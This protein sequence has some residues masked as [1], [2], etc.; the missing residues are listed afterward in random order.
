MLTPTW[1][2]GYG[3]W[4]GKAIPVDIVTMSPI[5]Q[6]ESAFLDELG[7]RIAE[8]SEDPRERA[9]LH[10]GI[11]IVIQRFNSIAFRD[12]FID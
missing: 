4:V 10:Q 11:S 6:K 1:A 3:P 7:N 2:V 12:T 5:N 9:F 8:I